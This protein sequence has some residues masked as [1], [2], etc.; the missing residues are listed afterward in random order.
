MEKA[1]KSEKEK[2]VNQLL[3]FGVSE[4]RLE[5]MDSLIENTVW[6]KIKLDDTRETIKNSQVAISY[7]NGGGQKGIRENPLY[8][9]YCSLF[10]AYMSGM[11][12]IFSL[13]P[14]EAIEQVETA[15]KP[16]TMLE[17]VRSR[18]GA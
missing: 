9:G 5:I 4:Q 1:V 16:K 11:E 3:D 13:L 10:K 14:K 2:L 17:I 7:D 8:K 18:H 15:D 12:K 6:M